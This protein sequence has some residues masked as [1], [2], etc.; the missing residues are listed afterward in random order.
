MKEYKIVS[1]IWEDHSSFSGQSLPTDLKSLIRPSITMGLLYKKTKRYLVI[2][3]HIERFDYADEADFTVILRDSVL[4][5]K[6]HGRLQLD[7][8]RPKEGSP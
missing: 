6:E 8:L 7:N 4:G 1:V 2:A 3:Y 5:I